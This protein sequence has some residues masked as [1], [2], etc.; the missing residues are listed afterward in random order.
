VD[1]HAF[2]TLDSESVPEP[3]TVAL[4]GLGMLAVILASRRQLLARKT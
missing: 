1:V 4:L 2:L 3:G